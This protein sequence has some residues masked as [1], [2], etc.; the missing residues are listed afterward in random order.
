MLE[1]IEPLAPGLADAVLAIDVLS[2]VDLEAAN[3]NAIG[4]NPYGGSTSLDQS[5]LWRPLVSAPSHQTPVPGLWHIG[6]STHPGP[7][8]GGSSGHLVAQRLIGAGRDSR[9]LIT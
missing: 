4:G 9:T 1:H 5:Y 7:G 8:L 3:P 2:P 6:S